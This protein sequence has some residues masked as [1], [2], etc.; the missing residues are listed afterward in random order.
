MYLPL[1]L[2]RFKITF[3]FME[4]L[5]QL[6]ER[7]MA[8]LNELEALKKEN[9][10]LIDQQQ[11]VLTELAEENSSLQA[12]LEIEQQRNN[13]ALE[14]IDSLVQRIKERLDNQ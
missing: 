12:R 10:S 4:L 11:T 8:L 9:A 1:H 14:R 5:E 7:V 6:E 2:P 13:S 3:L